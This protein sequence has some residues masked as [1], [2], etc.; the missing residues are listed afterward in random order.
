MP[1]VAQEP[2]PE[3]PILDPVESYEQYAK[4]V[5]VS[6]TIL[7]AGGLATLGLL[8]VVAIGWWRA[9]KPDEGDERWRKTLHDDMEEKISLEFENESLPRVAISLRPHA[10]VV[11]SPELAEKKMKVT[12][13]I[14]GVARKDAISQ[15]CKRVG[16]AWDIRNGAIFIYPEGKAPPL[17]K[18]PSASEGW[19]PETLKKLSRRISFQMYETPL[20]RAVHFINSLAR[21]K[22]VLDPRLENADDP[23]IFMCPVDDMRVD[24]TLTWFCLLGNAEWTRKQA[25]DGTDI[26]WVAPREGPSER[27]SGASERSADKKP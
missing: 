16:A 21:V 22:I 7:A 8:I 18:R 9:E 2:K 12:W 11:L 13:R 6:Q 4:R 19:K 20:A 23:R 25:D 14:D 10:F 24:D 17:R 3:Y 5:A 27:S 1:V 15:F 26:I